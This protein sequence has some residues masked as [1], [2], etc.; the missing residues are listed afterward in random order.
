MK[1]T[2]FTV[3][4]LAASAIAAPVVKRA[5]TSDAAPYGYAT[6]NGGLYFQIK[7]RNI[8]QY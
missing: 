5:T 1:F 3:F 7:S 2:L 6:L 4:A 8:D